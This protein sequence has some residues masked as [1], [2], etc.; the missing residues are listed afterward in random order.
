MLWIKEQAKTLKWI[1]PYSHAS[2]R[3]GLQTALRDDD[4]QLSMKLF[5][6]V[7]ADDVARIFGELVAEDIP[8]L[9]S[10]LMEALLGTEQID[11]YEM[12]KLWTV[13]QVGGF[14]D[15]VYFV[16][17]DV[18]ADAGIAP[19]PLQQTSLEKNLAHT[20]TMNS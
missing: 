11:M 6:G 10:I 20:P 3:I 16:D 13:G 14:S 9:P 7:S 2:G 1:D 4:R 5:A 15:L 12:E 8:T 17:L 18:V 19:M